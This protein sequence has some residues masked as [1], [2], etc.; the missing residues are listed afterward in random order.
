MPA[1]VLLHAETDLD[2]QA[3]DD[4]PGCIVSLCA[5]SQVGGQWVSHVLAEWRR[6]IGQESRWQLPY[7][8]A[9]KQGAHGPLLRRR[10]TL[11]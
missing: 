10:W 11:G 4:V 3:E 9:V 6:L 2:K 5:C 7:T 1:Q 8:A